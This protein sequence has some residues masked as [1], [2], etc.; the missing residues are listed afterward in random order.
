[1]ERS[2]I[3]VKGRVQQVGFRFY[4]R[5]IALQ[6][7][8]TGW[9]KNLPDGNVEIVVEGEKAQIEDF[10]QKL[11]EGYLGRNISDIVRKTE[12]YTGKFNYFDIAF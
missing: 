2:H 3:L 7:N 12:S 4:A 5:E 11:Q 9:V 10:L 6:T 1:M 8:V